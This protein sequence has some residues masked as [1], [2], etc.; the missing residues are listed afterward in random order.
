MRYKVVN[1]KLYNVYKP[2]LFLFERKVGE[3]FKTAD[4][5]HGALYKTAS[6]PEKT[7]G[8]RIS[9]ETVFEQMKELGK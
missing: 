5:W 8:P 6:K 1:A 7:F 4:G 9:S 3:I 2:F